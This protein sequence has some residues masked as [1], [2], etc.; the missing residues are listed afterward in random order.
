MLN[1]WMSAL[2]H[3]DGRAW[4]TDYGVPHEGECVTCHQVGG[5]SMFIGPAPR[6]LQRSVVRDGAVIDQL[7]HLSQLGVLEPV[8]SDVAS[9]LPD[10]TDAAAS[11]EERARAYLD[12]NCAHCHNPQGWDEVSGRDM[13]FRY[14][15]PLGRSGM[16]RKAGDI[17][18]AMPE[19]PSG[20]A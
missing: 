8:P 13:D 17:L 12:I 16:D 18:R 15:T 10:Y 11:P 20:V 7:T 6:N 9:P 19:R 4:S 14:A 2:P 5:A 3:T 1:P